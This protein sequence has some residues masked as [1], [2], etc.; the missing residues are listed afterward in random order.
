MP[1]TR[2]EA[3]SPTRREA[4]P[5]TR[6]EAPSPTRHSREGGNPWASNRRARNRMTA[7]LDRLIS[8][9]STQHGHYSLVEKI[10]STSS[11]FRLSTTTSFSRELCPWLYE[12]WSWRLPK[13]RPAAQSLPRWP[14]PFPAAQSPAPATRRPGIRRFCLPRPLVGLLPSSEFQARIGRV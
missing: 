8:Q 9:I 10:R 5:P 4:P 7:L 12:H 14:A 2:R 11:E 6:R 13:R 1:P 3:P